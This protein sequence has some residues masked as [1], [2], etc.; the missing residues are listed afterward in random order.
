MAE[1]QLSI[2][3]TKLILVSP[4]TLV[5]TS[6]NYDKCKFTFGLEWNDYTKT[7]IFYS[8]INTEPV[9]VLL[10]NDGT[11]II[12]WESLNDAGILY[13]GVS[14][15]KDNIE[16]HTNY[17][18]IRVTLG[19]LC[20]NPPHPLTLDIYG[21]ILS[22]L[23]NVQITNAVTWGD[24]PDKP[25]IP[26]KTSELQNDSGYI[27]EV[28]KYP[29][30]NGEV[31][32]VNKSFPYGNV[33]RYGA[34]GDGVSDDTLAFSNGLANGDIFI[35]NGKYMV[36]KLF[37]PANRTI[38]GE[39]MQNTWIYIYYPKANLYD[40]IMYIQNDNVVMRDFTFEMTVNGNMQGDMYKGF[41]CLTIQN[42]SNVKLMNIR[43]Q[44]NGTGCIYLV[45]ARYVHFNGCEFINVDTGIN[46]DPGENQ[47]SFIYIEN[48]RFDGHTY[49]EPITFRN[50]DNIYIRNCDIRNKP[51]GSGI[52]LWGCENVIVDGC[53]LY[54]LN[55]GIWITNDKDKSG[56]ISKNVV[57]TNCKLSDNV[58]DGIRINNNSKNIVAKNNVFSHQNNAVAGWCFN[59]SN[60]SAIQIENNTFYH[61][62]ANPIHITGKGSPIGDINIISNYFYPQANN[63]VIIQLENIT[64][65]S[66][67]IIEK[68]YFYPFNTENT[69]VIDMYNIG[70]SEKI[71]FYGNNYM[72]GNRKI[73]DDH[74]G[75][76]IT[77]KDELFQCLL[78][79]YKDKQTSYYKF[80]KVG[81]FYK[82]D[83][84]TAIFVSV[85]TSAGYVPKYT[86]WQAS[87][88]YW[89]K[90]T[91]KI[92]NNIYYLNGDGKS[93]NSQPVESNG[94][95]ITDGTL[96]W[97]YLGTIAQFRSI[98]LT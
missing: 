33:R 76:N 36:L 89:I 86:T 29:I 97:K 4:Q 70:G 14:G 82:K 32:V 63:L 75:V 30:L 42:A 95:D 31:G 41:C 23:N 47:C 69:P 28:E 34:K 12:P 7:V 25:T 27:T 67:V 77:L 59:I 10:N 24:I 9:A 11:C 78:F 73:F 91:M 1:I 17:I 19:T 3:Q 60:S 90:E 50:A 92:G 87:R 39:S 83:N 6:A 18:C 55:S 8:N 22:K 35:P 66:Q 57:V 13:I 61:V 20:D 40:N 52:G 45:K 93:G 71:I 84:S 65:T 74:Y 2:N 5:D 26:T 21:Q 88:N 56:K 80:Y 46:S 48:C 44:N 81:D 96:T 62:Y 64:L 85:C 98:N 68:N 51:K 79:D 43:C 49:S 54:N 53:Y 58:V 37:V 16:K 72:G 38:S 15:I 94:A